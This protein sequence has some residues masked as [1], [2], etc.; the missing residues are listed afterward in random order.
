MLLASNYRRE[1]EVTI[2]KCSI[3]YLRLR[4]GGDTM[5]LVTILALI[6]LASAAFGQYSEVLYPGPGG[7][8]GENWIA[9]RGV[10]FDPTPA[11]I[12]GDEARIDDGRLQRLDAST[13]N[14][15]GYLSFM[16]EE[17]GGMLLG[18]G[19]TVL[20]DNG[21]GYTINYD[22]APDGLPDGAGQK[23]DMWISLPGQTGMNGGQHFIGHPFDH[24]VPFV[25][26]LVTDG[27]RTIPVM[28][29]IAEGW[30]E[31]YWPYLDGP[32]QSVLQV[33]PD[34]IVGSPYLEPGHMYVVNTM[35]ANLAL[36]I[37][38]AQ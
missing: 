11:V 7:S 21:T 20:V 4:K 32:T 29:A 37:P 33:D 34:E 13:Q 22:G 1:G 8:I 10:P 5:R 15:Y 14:V 28:N 31:G 24:A 36:I 19:F 17:F 18:D 35:K 27:T 30:L 16:P 12:F 3:D 26:V 23:T 25:N 6:L 38:P 2:M 9:L